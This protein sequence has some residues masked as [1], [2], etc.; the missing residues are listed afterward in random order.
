MSAHLDPAIG[1]GASGERYCVTHNGVTLIESTKNPEFDS[2]RALLALGIFGR[3]EVWRRGAS[4]PAMRLD[5]EKCARLTVE[6]GDCE[7]LRF[8]P[9]RPLSLDNVSDPVSCRAISARRGAYEG[10]AGTLACKKRPF[11][12]KPSR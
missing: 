1:L 9:W 8:V 10:A 3:I 11:S 2:A 7:G 5:I 12:I 4:S 6:E